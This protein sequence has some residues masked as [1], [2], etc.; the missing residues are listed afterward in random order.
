MKRESGEKNRALDLILKE[1]SKMILQ[2][3]GGQ[4]PDMMGSER[5]SK[6]SQV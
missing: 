3:K 1:E 2:E 5:Q 4:R 6:V